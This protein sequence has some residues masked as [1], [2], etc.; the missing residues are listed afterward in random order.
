MSIR[1][2]WILAKFIVSHGKFGKE[3]QSILSLMN[4]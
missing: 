2:A 3:I 4:K 1:R